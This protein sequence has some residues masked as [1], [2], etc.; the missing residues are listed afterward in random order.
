MDERLE[1]LVECGEV[2]VVGDGVQGVV[3]AVVALVFPDMD[4]FHQH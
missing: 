4:L 1:L 2:G 3:V